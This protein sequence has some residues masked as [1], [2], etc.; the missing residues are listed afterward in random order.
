[1]LSK[2]EKKIKLL[3]LNPY[4]SAFQYMC[5]IYITKVVTPPH[6]KYDYDEMKRPGKRG[7]VFSPYPIRFY[8]FSLPF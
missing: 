2:A 1:M 3:L 8:F 6:N 7:P 5:N 4:I